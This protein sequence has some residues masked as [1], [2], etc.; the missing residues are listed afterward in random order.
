M[1]RFVLFHFWTIA[2]QNQTAYLIPAAKIRR[3]TQPTTKARHGF[4]TKN[5]KLSTEYRNYIKFADINKVSHYGNIP[6]R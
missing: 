6:K 5:K 3:F 1:F 4:S 2:K